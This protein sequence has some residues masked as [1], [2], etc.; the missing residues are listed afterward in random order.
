[1]HQL[2]RQTHTVQKSIL[3]N[4][5]KYNIKLNY[6]NC[7]RYFDHPLAEG[8]EKSEFAKQIQG[9][10]LAFGHGVVILFFVCVFSCTM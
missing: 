9:F 10:F 1:M 4:I 7:I 6:V 3:F 2:K 5:L 8:Q